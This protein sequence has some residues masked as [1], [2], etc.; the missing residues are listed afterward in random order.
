MLELLGPDAPS[1]AK[2]PVASTCRWAGQ[3]LGLAWL[4]Q[5]K[6]GLKLYDQAPAQNT[7]HL[8][9]GSSYSDYRMTLEDWEMAQEMVSSP[10]FLNPLVS[11]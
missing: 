9:D 7:A 10:L 1:P 8:D 6:V 11:F 3:L 5:T 4:V 2:P